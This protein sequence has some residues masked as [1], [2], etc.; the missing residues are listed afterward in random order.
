MEEQD[1]CYTTVVRDCVF[2]PINVHVHRVEHATCKTRMQICPGV[3][4]ITKPTCKY[5]SGLWAGASDV[6]Y[7]NEP[8]RPSYEVLDGP[9]SLS[10][11]VFHGP[12]IKNSTQKT[13][14]AQVDPWWPLKRPK[15]PKHSC[16]RD[17]DCPVIP[18]MAFTMTH[19]PQAPNLLGLR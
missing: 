2:L 9:P 6:L 14:S 4:R 18:V 16:H 8:M 12:V 19:E 5:A 7:E 17:S 3:S 11:Q 15:N 10:Y 13:Q 1:R